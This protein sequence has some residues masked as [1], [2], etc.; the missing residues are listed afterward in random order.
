MRNSNLLLIRLNK[1]VDCSNSKYLSEKALAI[2]LFDNLIETHLHHLLTNKIFINE[3]SN[4]NSIYHYDNKQLRYYEDILKY[5]KKEK[6]LSVDEYK[7]LQFTHK[8]R[9]KIYHE[10]VIIKNDIDLTIIL[11]YLF[12]KKK[13]VDWEEAAGFRIFSDNVDDEQIDFG[14]GLIKET[15]PFN[16]KKYFFKAWDYIIQKW[17]IK[18]NLAQTC[19]INI[20]NQIESIENSIGYLVNTLKE[21]NYLY[22]TSYYS[23]VKAQDAEDCRNLNFI[24][25]VHMFYRLI[26]ENTYYKK[27]I[28]NIRDFIKKNNK[29]YP[30]WVDI[31]K[32]KKRIENFRNLDD[33]K[34]LDKYVEIATRLFDLYQDTYNAECYLSGYLQSLLDEYL[35]K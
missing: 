12:L 15:F 34:V 17:E 8:Q 14:Q 31:N 7:I 16:H 21:D 9:N 6:L 20:T 4:W 23:F 27:N 13:R 26:N 35:G 3:K 11:Y 24:L 2:I 32:I 1:A 19:K 33:E 28:L 30:K 29:V 5:A 18:N 10:N 25:L 22:Q